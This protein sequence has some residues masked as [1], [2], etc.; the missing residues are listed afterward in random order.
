M[1]NQDVVVPD[2]GIA[3]AA[4]LPPP[5]LFACRGV[6]GAVS[7]LRG[8]YGSLGLPGGAAAD[9]GEFRS[10]VAAAANAPPG[11]TSCTSRVVEA[12][13]ASSPARCP[14]V[15]EYDAWTRKHPSALGSFDQIA[16]AAKGKR[17][18]MF[19]DYDGT[20]SPI[21]ADPDMAFMTPE[22]R[23]AVRNVAKRFPTAI[24][25]GRCIEKVCSFV[26]LPELYYAGSHGMDIKGPNSKS[27]S[28]LAEKVKAVLR[29]FPELELTEGRKVVEVR[30]SIMWDKGKAVE[31]LL[32][33]LGFDDDRTN[34]LP[35]YIGD[36]R[37]DEDA[38]KV[39]R[40]RGQGIGILV[41]KCPKETDA[42]YSLQDPTEVMEFLVRLGQWNPLRSPSPAARPRGRKQ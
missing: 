30:P 7:S 35:V 12:I 17:V 2:M 32:R 23:A 40:E 41:S 1:T 24:V 25:T 29:D 16:A 13:R 34:V 37:T 26:G 3:A 39:L 14:A 10:P 19:M 21:V 8:T 38:F 33:S 4:A 22:M 15:D 11:R 42:T 36:D 31:F 27:W 18:V 5:G 28:S 9:G 6:A 20:L